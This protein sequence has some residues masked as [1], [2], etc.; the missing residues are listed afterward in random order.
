MLTLNHYSIIRYTRMIE[1][2]HIELVGD[3]M[4]KGGGGWWWGQIEDSGNVLTRR[5]RLCKLMSA[6]SMVVMSVLLAGM[7]LNIAFQMIKLI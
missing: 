6:I 3:V 1:P 5:S 4:G 7:H 2:C